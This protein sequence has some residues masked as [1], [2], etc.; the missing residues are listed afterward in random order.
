MTEH[1]S[2]A[3]RPNESH[4]TFLSRIGKWFR[5]GSGSADDRRADNGAGDLPLMRDVSQSTVIEPRGTFLRPWAKRDAQIESLANGF[6]TLTDLM[7]TIRDNLEQQN[8]RQE[9]L[10]RHMS[11][12]PQVLQS[13]PES[14]RLHSET[15]R[16][17]SQQIEHQ[18]GQQSKLADIL[19]R[20][21]EADQQQRSTLDAL[22]DRVENLNQ[23][24]QSI[25]ENLG[26]VGAAMQSVSKNSS[27]SAAVLEQMRDNLNSRDGELE[28]ILHKQ[29]N[30][31]TTMLAVAIFL[32]I[33]AL[34]AVAVMGYLGYEA[35]QRAQ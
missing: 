11:H 27:A 12:L 26:N 4:G 14:S 24:D 16:A 6:N 2:V 29:G 8:R 32:S 35:L 1:D 23:T 34:V 21:V 33:S 15:L 31:F 9:E 7:G 17:I 20:I 19:G 10:L 13:I 30:R 3:E 22:T 18:S 5:P 28:R 25:A